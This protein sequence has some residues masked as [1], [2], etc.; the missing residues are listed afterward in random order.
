METLKLDVRNQIC[1]S[2]LLVALREINLHQAALRKGTLAL[3]VLSDNRDSTT[4]IAEAAENMGYRVNVSKE[5][6]HYQLTIAGRA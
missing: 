6:N 3:V 5:E 1:P 2:T 4:R